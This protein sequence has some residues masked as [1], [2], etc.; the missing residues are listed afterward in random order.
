MKTRHYQNENSKCIGEVTA[1]CFVV[2]YSCIAIIKLALSSLYA[3]PELLVPLH[4]W[5]TALSGSGSPSEDASMFFLFCSPP[6][7]LYYW[8]L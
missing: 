4:L 1:N 8:D 5:A 3:D 2:L 6:P 7:S